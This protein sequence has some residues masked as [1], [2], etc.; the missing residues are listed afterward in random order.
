M[1]SYSADGSVKGKYDGRSRLWMSGP[2]YAVVK[3]SMVPARS[4]KLMPR[5]TTSPSIWWKVGMWRASGV[6]RR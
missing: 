3:V 6:S 1:I 4:A 5:S 2:K